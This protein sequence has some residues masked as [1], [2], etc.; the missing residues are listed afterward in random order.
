MSLRPPLEAA[1]QSWVAQL[2]AWIGAV[3]DLEKL[4]SSRYDVALPSKAV[5][6]TEG[7]KTY[8]YLLT[9]LP[10]GVL[11]QAYAIIEAR[12]GQVSKY[13]DLWLQYQ[14][15]WDIDANQLYGSLGSDLAAWSQLLVEIKEARKTI[16]TSDSE[17]QFGPIVINYAQ[18]QASV[19][20]KYDFWQRDV[21]VH[22]GAKLGEAM[23]SF[24]A[25]LKA[26]RAE[27]E[28]TSLD[29]DSTAD[30]VAL[31]IQV[32]ELKKKVTGWEVQVKTFGA[33]QQMLQ[34]NRF[35][36]PSDWLDFGVIEGEWSAFMELLNK[37]N[38]V[39]STEIPMLQKKILGESRVVEEKIKQFCED[40]NASKPPTDDARIHQ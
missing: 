11:R 22:F 10:A 26:A 2:N 27:L 3:C 20:N 12:I 9:K 14:A 5:F 31:I 39:I 24:Y 16:D 25:I 38:N 21:L 13:V 6:A 7:K 34:R 1:R 37:K 18:V 19:N 15:L 29:T 35:Q 33:G 8:R 36:F 17:K 28:Q 40:W 32:Q 30:A 23:N 4:L